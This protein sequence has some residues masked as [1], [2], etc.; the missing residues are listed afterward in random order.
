[1]YHQLILDIYTPF[2]STCRPH[3]FRKAVK[4]AERAFWQVI[5]RSR[6]RSIWKA[7]KYSNLHSSWPVSSCTWYTQSDI[8]VQV[9]LLLWSLLSKTQNLNWQLYSELLVI[10]HPK[11]M[12]WKGIFGILDLNKIRCV[13]QEKHKISWRETG[14]DCYPGSGIHQNLGRGMWDFFPSLSGT[15]NHDDSIRVLG[16]KCDSTRRAFSCVSYQ[17][18]KIYVVMWVLSNW[19]FKWWTD[20]LSGQKTHYFNQM[21][22]KCAWCNSSLINEIF[23]LF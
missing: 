5:Y 14:F 6:H 4:Q 7:L 21:P 10:S 17:L 19:K 2:Y 23:L 18:S 15:G 11:N 3:E 16:G 1:M 8:L 9:A 22:R 12:V 13:I 20:E